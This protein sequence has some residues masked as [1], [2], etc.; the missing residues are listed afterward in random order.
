MTKLHLQIS[1]LD[2]LMFRDGRPFNQS[3]EGASQ[4]VSVFPPF[5]PT[6]VGA[7]RAAL[8]HYLGKW[9]ED[10]LG[11]GTDWQE[12]GKLGKLSFS[13]PYIM[14]EKQLVFPVPLHLLGNASED[15]CLLKPDSPKN[16]DLGKVRLPVPMDS[17]IKGL[18]NIEDRWIYSSGIKKILNGKLPADTDFIETSKIWQSET[19]VGIGIDRKSRR[20]DVNKDKGGMLYMASHVRLSDQASLHIEMSG[21]AG[22]ADVFSASKPNLISLGGE[23]RA[24]DI[25]AVDAS[26]S[27]PKSP[28]KL[29]KEG[30]KILYTVY[31]T[32][33]CVLD[34]LGDIADLL[35]GELVSACLG[36]VQMIGGWD[37]ENKRP[38]PLRPALPAG[39]VCFMQADAEK[40]KEILALHGCHIGVGRE[41]GFG[42]ILIGTWKE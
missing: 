41:W 22:E 9:N 13:P 36:K 4:A 37:S 8:W 5:P 30:N 14:H 26:I 29:N 34:E 17:S 18:K 33:P 42:Q 27:L 6:M 32:S 1:P 2:S 20:T 25:L 31:F 21:W 7:V 39:S 15:R 38:V 24:A 3:D 11:D 28:K 35:K 40:E 10:L 12:E 23:H 19:R 16:C